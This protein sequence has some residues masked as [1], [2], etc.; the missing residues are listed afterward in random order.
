MA[1]SWDDILLDTGNGDLVYVHY[2]GKQY[3]DPEILKNDQITF[4]G[5]YDGKRYYTISETESER[6][7]YLTA[8]YSSINA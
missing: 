5:K 3:H 2:E 7:P 6:L 1:L 4:Y 8:Q